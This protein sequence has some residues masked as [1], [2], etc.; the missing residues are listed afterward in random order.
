MSRLRAGFINRITAAWQKTVQS[1]LDVGHLLLVA[2]KKLPHGD[3]M[4]MVETDLPFSSRTAECLMSIA[5]HPRLAKANPHTCANLPTGW[6]A[7]YELSR[8]PVRQ[9]DALLQ[10]RRICADTTVNEAR[11]LADS[12]EWERRAQYETAQP[13]TVSI[14][15]S[16]TSIPVRTVAYV[17]EA[18][19]LQ[20]LGWRARASGYAG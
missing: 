16:H 4:A 7:L 13:A 1:I 9:F 10:D 3:F 15:L 12:A 20:G 18:R 14:Q 11:C 19:P 2:K 6:R 5:R 17:G 8:L